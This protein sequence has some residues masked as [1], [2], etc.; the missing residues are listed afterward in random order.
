MFDIYTDIPQDI[1]EEAA[2]RYIDDDPQLSFVSL[3]I[4]DDIFVAKGFYPPQCSAS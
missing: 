2:E 1:W 4:K 3:F